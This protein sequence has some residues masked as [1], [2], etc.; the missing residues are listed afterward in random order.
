DGHDLTIY[1]R[2]ENA[3]YRGAPSAESVGAY[4]AVP[5]AVADVVTILLGGPPARAAVGPA[6][7][8]RDDAAG[9]IRLSIPL[10]DGREEVWWAPESLLPVASETPLTDGR[11]LRVDFDDYRS[12]AGTP[13]PYRI[14]MRAE[15]GD[16]LVRVRYTSPE[17]NAAIGADRFALAPPAGASE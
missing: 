4:T 12:L 8:G 13:F 3:V 6:T 5:I 11:V 7:V 15:P 10:A 16:R 1:V 14:A 9:L 2:R 17:L